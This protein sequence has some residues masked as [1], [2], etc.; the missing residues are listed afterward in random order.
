[1]TI[2]GFVAKW[3]YGEPDEGGQM[4][5]DLTTLLAAEREACAK[6]AKSVKQPGKI[7]GYDDW[8]IAVEKVAAEIRDTGRAK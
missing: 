5:Y 1:M 6:V 4:R 3:G 7:Y 2:E 8:V